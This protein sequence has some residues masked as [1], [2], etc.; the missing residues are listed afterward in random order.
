MTTFSPS[1]APR[2]K[3]ATRIFLRRSEPSAAYTERD[4]HV[5]RAPTPN[6]AS[7]EPFRKT[8]REVI[9][10]LPSLKI[11]RAD[12][13]SGLRRRCLHTRHLILGHLDREIHPA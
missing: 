3:M 5:G 1:T 9:E 12:H 2:W 8:R 10:N 4:S 13:F 7:A 6:I 11:R